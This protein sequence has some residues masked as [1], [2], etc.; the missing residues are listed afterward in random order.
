MHKTC[1]VNLCSLDH[2]VGDGG[3]ALSHKVKTHRRCNDRQDKCGVGVDHAQCCHYDVLHDVQNGR[4]KEKCDNY[5][6]VQKSISGE[7]AL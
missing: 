3:H 6:L 7:F 5:D 4:V 2:S 1:A